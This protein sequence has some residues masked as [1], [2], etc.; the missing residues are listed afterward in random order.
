MKNV[1][2][3]YNHKQKLLNIFFASIPNILSKI[4]AHFANKKGTNINNKLQH[5]SGK[6]K[7][8]TFL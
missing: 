3:I 4:K 1:R 8:T 2:V 5:F 7:R 6:Q